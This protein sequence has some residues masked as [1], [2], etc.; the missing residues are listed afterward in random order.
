MN[1]LLKMLLPSFAIILVSV[2]VTNAGQSYTLEQCKSLALKNNLKMKNSALELQSS[3]S[4][5]NSAFTKYFPQA[6][7]NGFAFWA[8]SDLVEMTQKGGNLPVYDGN[9]A[10]LLHPTEFAYF[11][12]QKISM[13]DRLYLA[14]LSVVQ[15]LYTG[16]RIVTGNDL[17][18]LGIEVNEE[19]SNLAKKEVELKTVEYYWTI[20][21]LK[22][23]LN[24]IDSYRSYLDTLY[25]E[26]NSALKAGLI[27]KN[28]LLKISLK[29]N[30]LAIN[31]IRLENAVSLAWM[32]FCRFMGTEYETGLDLSE[33]PGEVETPD[34]YRTD[35][36]EALRNRIEYRLLQKSVEAE[37]LQ[38]KLKMGEYLPE[39]AVGAAVIYN[40]VL[41]VGKFNAIAFGKI[42]VPLSGWWEASYT[43][44]DREVKEQ[45][46]RNNADDANGQM[47]LQMQK[48]W[49]DLSEVYRQYE[50]AKLSV[51]QA[52]ENVKLNRDNYN[53]G[54][55]NISDLLE[56]QAALQQTLDQLTGIRADYRIKAATYLNVTGR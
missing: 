51:E 32:D 54:I 36:R 25:K 35:H 43:K 4:T 6:G 14:N 23:K 1:R 38:T 30:E 33:A 7:L 27:N 3:R 5:K 56:A 55:I 28:D 50:L 12:D 15:P 19:K 39:A 40:N 47:M 42:S 13:L 24:T 10:N 11:P 48:A 44:E 16:G 21:S 31:R 49:N 53:S 41:D 26:A 20:Y 2:A 37:E 46:A 34:S 45:I 29:Q 8:A 22:E 9:P 52:G 17:A 18:E